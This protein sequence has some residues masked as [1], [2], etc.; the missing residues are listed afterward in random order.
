M[1][2]R[3]AI[4]NFI[5]M[6][7]LAVLLAVL[8]FVSFTIPASNYKFAGFANAITTDI[9]L[10]GGYSATYNIEFDE[11]TI[12]SSESVN[13]AVLFIKNKLNE[14]GYGSSTVQSSGIENLVIDIPNMLYAYDI[15]NAVG[16]NG[17]LYIRTTETTD[18][19]ETDI[20][21]EDVKDIYS[22]YA[23]ISATDYKW[24]TT[25]E[26][27]ETGKN[28]IESLTSSGSGTIY[29]YVGDEVF[30][31]ISFSS[32]VTGDSL[33]VYGSSQNEDSANVYAFTMLMGTLG[34]NFSLS[35]NEIITIPPTFGDNALLGSGIAVAIVLI[36]FMVAVFFMFGDFGWLINLSLILYAVLVIFLMQSM[37]IFSL[38][39]SGIIGSIVGLALLFASYCVIFGNI[40]KGYA[41]GKKIPLAVRAGYKKS[42]LTVVDINV[43]AF[44]MA[45]ITY[46]AGGFILN[47]F[48]IALGICS[49][50][51][52]FV[53]LLVTRWFTKWYLSINSTKPEKLHMKRGAN[54][55]ELN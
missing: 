43:I 29:I 15:L 52:I 10:K 54:V 35:N 26:F 14:Y 24:G 12:Q 28:K 17:A 20:I 48:A 47:S 8:C 3:L 30:S 45:V 18:I 40:K 16:T 33:Y 51:N 53:S 4:R 19:A 7:I 44:I 21:G 13:D 55:N 6:S 34:M 32:A 42:I 49:A 31:R 50:L 22:T 46:F 9:D 41:E 39:I 25:I 37:P 38:S 2:K 23:Q 1:T 5:L 36:L 27:T 11:K